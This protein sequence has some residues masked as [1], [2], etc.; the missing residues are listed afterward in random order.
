MARKRYTEE[1]IVSILREAQRVGASREVIRR[2]GISDQTFCRRKRMYGGMEVSQVPR[3]KEVEDE[4]W[5]RKQLL[6][7][8]SLVIDTLKEYSKKG[9]DVAGPASGHTDRPQSGL[10]V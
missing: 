6:G 3:I 4:N 10:G 8:Q 7:E 2:H 9:L 1:L 5:K